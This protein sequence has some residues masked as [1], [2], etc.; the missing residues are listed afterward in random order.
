PVRRMAQSELSGSRQPRHEAYP[1]HAGRQGLRLD[2]GHADEGH[3]AVCLDDR[4][5]VRAG[6]RTPRP[7]HAASRAHHRAFPLAAAAYRTVEP[8]RM[9]IPSAKLTAITLGVRDV[10]A[11]ARFYEALGFK[12]KMRATGNEIAFMDGGCVVL[13][14]SDWDKLVD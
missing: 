10:A 9:T 7:Q 14:L 12:R 2:L 3:R 11:S 5:A 8:V 4:A 1:R 6:L 13:S